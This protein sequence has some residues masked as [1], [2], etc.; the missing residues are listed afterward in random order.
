MPENED[1]EPSDEL[2][3]PESIQFIGFGKNFEEEIDFEKPMWLI[4]VFY[5][6]NVKLYSVNAETKEEA[7]EMVYPHLS[8]IGLERI[9]VTRMEMPEGWPGDAGLNAT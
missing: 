2:N 6:S 3:D 5:T 7:A 4:E 9:I 8:I 1:I